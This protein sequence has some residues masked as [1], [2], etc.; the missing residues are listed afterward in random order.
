MELRTLDERQPFT[1]LS[2]TGEAI[3]L[4]ISSGRQHRL[5]CRSVLQAWQAL[6]QGAELTRPR[7]DMFQPRHGTYLAAI[8]A[9][10][11][12]IDGSSWG[13][14]VWARR[15]Q[16]RYAG[17]TKRPTRSLKTKNIR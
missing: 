16:P 6:Q 11:P 1:V 12:D 8:L 5:L 14:S 3:D 10:L 9:R 7:L 15:R 4:T 13:E 17:G 2:V